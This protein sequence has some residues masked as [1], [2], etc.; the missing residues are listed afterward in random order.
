[1]ENNLVQKIRE[2]LSKNDNIGIVVG[3]NPS[4]D[5]MAGGLSLY[6]L[7]KEANKKVIIACPTQ[8]I[9]EISNLVGIDKVVNKL[10]GPGGDLVVSFPYNEGEIEKVSYT[11]EEGFLNIIVKSAG[12]GLSFSERDVKYSQGGESFNILFTVGVQ[13]ISDIGEL[14]SPDKIRDTKIINIDNNSSNQGFGDIVIVSPDYSSVS[15]QVADIVL[16]L[17]L[18]LDR[19]AAQ[20]LLSGIT[21][22]TNNFQENSTSPLA[23]EIASLLMRSGA[24]RQN[25][26]AQNVRQQSPRLTPNNFPQAQT[27]NQIN[28]F[29]AANAQ[30]RSTQAMNGSDPL[31]ATKAA[32]EAPNDWLSPKVF[33]GSSNF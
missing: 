33:K 19:D 16:S 31:Q 1:M 8:P 12:K 14:I 28:Q 24:S 3:K 22:A 7:L 11:L 29:N 15:E 27:T 4:L 17:G 25:N 23:F 10:D 2:L 26:I 21:F 13:N 9:V 6:L 32:D 18:R 30:S 5:Q 20:N